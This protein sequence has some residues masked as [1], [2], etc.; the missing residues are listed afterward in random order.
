[1]NKQ[2]KAPWAT[3]TSPR[4]L[5]SAVVCTEGWA[6]RIESP[7]RV[8]KETKTKYL[9]ESDQQIF[10]PTKTLKR[11]QRT[12]VPKRAIRFTPNATDHRERSDRVKPLV[13]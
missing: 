8:I 6:G 5:G 1:M 3:D 12:L 2:M 9:I 13:G 11:G 4:L 10:L 7:C